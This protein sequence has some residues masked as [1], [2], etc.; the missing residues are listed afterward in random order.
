MIVGHSSN[1][2]RFFY[3]TLER[4][5]RYFRLSQ[6]DFHFFLVKMGEGVSQVD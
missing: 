1:D 3:R 5:Y 4:Q 2:F 6:I